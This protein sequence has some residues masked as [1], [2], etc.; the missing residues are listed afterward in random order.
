MLK[1]KNKNGQYEDFRGKRYKNVFEEIKMILDK[2]TKKLINE[3][4]QNRIELL[5]EKPNFVARDVVWGNWT[6]ENNG[7]F[8]V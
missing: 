3:V 6:K 4:L 5:K 7:K 1:K 2:E 8:I